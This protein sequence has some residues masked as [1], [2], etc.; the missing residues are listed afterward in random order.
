MKFFHS[1]RAKLTLWYALILGITL[2]GSGVAAYIVTR[3][4]MI[5]NL[6]QSLRNEALWVNEFIEPKAKKIRLKRAAIKELQEVKRAAKA[7]TDRVIIAI[8]DSEKAISDDM[9]NKIY[10]HT[11]LS[12]QRHYIQILDRNGDVLYRSQSLHDYQLGYPEIPYQWINVVTAGGPDNNLVRLALMQTDYVKIF[13]AYPLAPVYEVLDSV[14]YN[15]L[16]IAP[17]ALF[18]SIVGGWFLGRKSLR[19][20][21]A[22]TKAARDITAQN[23]SQ[24]LPESD[25]D[26][27][28]GRLTIQ[29]NDMIERLQKSFLQVQQFSAD[30]SHELRTPLTIMRGEIEVALRNQRM[31]KQS[32][33]LL[34]SIYD[35]LIRLSSI[36]E[37]LMLLIKSDTG[38]LVFTMRPIA[39]DAFIQELI[40]D[41][42][43]L[44][45]PK[46]IDV[47]LEYSEP[48]VIHGDLT[49]LK[50]VFINLVDNAMKYTPAHGSV[51]LSLIN[52]GGNACITVKDT[53]VGIPAD[54]LNKIFERFYRVHRLHPTMEDAGGSGLGLSIAKWIIEAHHG[55]IDVQSREGQGSTFTVKL[56]LKQ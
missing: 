20:V 47:S 44:A 48:A 4:T 12:P 41:A 18:V 45:K 3:E 23:L 52:D 5:Q 42:Q 8:S 13:V 11:L 40:E 10:Q 27:E 9:W 53:G 51:T 32:R 16:F 15:L 25:V 54:D 1:I 36:V 24:R 21:D 29:F 7:D 6:D 28:L 50:Q 14:F 22:L 56:P 35:E 2:I 55:S 30:A 46:K 39:L 19:P 31:S 37:S 34:S 26:D 38:S 33:E 43:T 17:V 49:R